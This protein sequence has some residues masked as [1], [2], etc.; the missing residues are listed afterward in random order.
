MK[1]TVDRRNSG[2]E[3]E[4][5]QNS[6][7]LNAYE[8]KKKKHRDNKNNNSNSVHVMQQGKFERPTKKNKN[9]ND[10]RHYENLI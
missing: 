6:T 1:W 3:A 5:H 9:L 2:W 7:I 4:K 8:M 10:L